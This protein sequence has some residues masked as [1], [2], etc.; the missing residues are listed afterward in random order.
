M[1]SGSS[2]VKWQVGG[3]VQT[4][5]QTDPAPAHCVLPTLVNGTLRERELCRSEFFLSEPIS[6]ITEVESWYT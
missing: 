5:A 6:G 3:Q 1:L 2:K 4:Q